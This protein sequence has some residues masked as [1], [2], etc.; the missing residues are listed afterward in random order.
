MSTHRGD[1]PVTSVAQWNDCDPRCSGM[2]PEPLTMYFDSS[3]NRFLVTLQTSIQTNKQT[4]AS[5]NSTSFRPISAT[6]AYP[7]LPSQV[8]SICNL[9]RTALYWFSG[10]SGLVVEYQ[11]RNREVAGLTHTRS[12][13]SNLE[14]VANLLCAQ[15]NS[16]SCPLRDGKWVV[17]TA[18]GQSLVWLIGAMV[19][20]LAAPW[21]QLSV[22]AGNG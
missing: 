14:Q 13:A 16:A 7:L 18:T 8:V 9:Q 1:I 17:A 3:C 11:T 12:T 20:L 2:I 19:C 6:S 22:S 10:C 15:A 4:H 21:V 5:K